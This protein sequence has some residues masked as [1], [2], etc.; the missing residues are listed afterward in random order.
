MATINDIQTQILTPIANAIRAKEGT[1]GKIPNSQLASRIENL[2]TGTKVEG[3]IDITENGTYD[4]SQYA[5]ANV[6]VASSGGEDTLQTLI[7][8]TKSCLYLFA[9]LPN[10]NLDFAK[11]LDTS[12]VTNMTSMFY[13]STNLTAIPFSLDTSNV[14]KMGNMFAYCEKLQTIPQLNTSNVT[15]MVNMF[16]N[17]EALQAIPELDM[18][19]VTSGTSMFAGCSL[20]EEVP[21]LN[22]IKMTS[23]SSF[24]LYCENLKT[25][26]ELNMIN[27][28]S[29]SAT[30]NFL[31]NCK[32]LENLTL[33]NIKI[34]LQIG[35]GTTWGHLI[36]L[37]SLIGIVKELINAGSSR[38][39]TMG[40][41]NLEKIANTYVKF[42]D[43]S[44]TTIATGTKGDVV[45]CESTDEG[46][47]LL[48]DY[49]TLKRWTLA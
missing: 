44:Q 46:A 18:S 22:T 49:A 36:T 6:S 4:V 13:K 34:A 19:K 23:F 16:Q 45:L 10:D 8:S 27:C 12:N 17:C 33:L 43:S 25:I 20:L 37:D 28:T 42:T 7:D 26:R 47:M 9:Y 21:P 2:Q 40:S 30:M 39:L 5:S 48:S 3:T 29:S 35:N 11:N 24:F 1:T 31:N 32:K 41:A 38:T 14:T 15:D